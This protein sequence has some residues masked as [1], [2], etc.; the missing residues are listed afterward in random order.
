MA[1]PLELK[2]KAIELRKQGYSIHNPE[3]QIAFWSKVT[4]V[5]M[6]Q[7]NKCYQKQ[8]SGRYKKAEYQGCLVVHYYDHRL[9]KAL[10]AYY[11]AFAEF[12]GV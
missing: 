4:N 6:E 5:P 2:E 11:T 1:H 8:N 10:T 12:M 3:Q 7:F 9:A